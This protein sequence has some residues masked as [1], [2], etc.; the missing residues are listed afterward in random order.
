MNTEKRE[1][2]INGGPSNSIK[3]EKKGREGREVDQRERKNINNK[4]SRGK[5]SEWNEREERE[6]NKH[7]KR[8]TDTLEE[9]LQKFNQIR[10]VIIGEQ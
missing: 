9:A 8:E 1:K 10:V 6:A 7:G 4:K 3:K 5:E 2:Y